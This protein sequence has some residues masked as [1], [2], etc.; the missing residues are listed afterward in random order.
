[1]KIDAKLTAFALDELEEPERSAVARAVAV[2][3]DAQ[4]YVDETRELAC[5]LKNEFG[6]ESIRPADTHSTNLIS[7]HDDPWFWSI[8]QPLAIAAVLAFCAIVAAVA[9]STYK[10]HHLSIAAQ[11]AAPA[12]TVEAE[13]GATPDSSSEIIGA[14]TVPNP[15]PIQSLGRLNRVVITER[16]SESNGELHVIEVIA[17][18]YRL[19]KLRESLLT[20]VLSRKPQ[21]GVIG[22]SYDLLFLNEEG[23]VVAS[24]SFYRAPGVGFV[25]QLSQHVP[26]SVPHDLG[27]H[28]TNALPGRWDSHVDYSAYAL[29]F[30]NWPDSIGYS[31][32]A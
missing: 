24:A 7:M 8:A 6:A 10:S 15:L 28:V 31:P 22:R 4:R 26:E 27:I 12:Y 5:S 30:P 16:A 11:R 23:D 2:S 19:N 13:M 32:G 9:L 14:T 29:L 18:N 17:D 25:L 3:P 1:M 21:A 20:P